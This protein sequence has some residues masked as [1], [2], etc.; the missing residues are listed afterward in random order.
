MKD[1]RKNVEVTKSTI[2]KCK[3]CPA[4]RDI[5]DVDDLGNPSFVCDVFCDYCS[6]VV[7]RCDKN[8][9]IERKIRIMRAFAAAKESYDFDITLVTAVMDMEKDK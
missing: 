4:C 7:D 5:D 1:T 9:L 8:S 6:L 2:A 3:L